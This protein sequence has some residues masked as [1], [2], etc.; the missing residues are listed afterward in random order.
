MMTGNGPR[1]SGSS[2]EQTIPAA[3]SEL[4]NLLQIVSG[5]VA[6]LEKVWEGQ[7]GS[8]KYFEMLRTT[9]DRASKVTDQLVRQVGGTEQ[10]ILFHP[11]LAAQIRARRPPPAP[12]KISRCILVVDDEP[13]AL[14]LSAQV[15]S[16]AGYTVVTTQSGVEALELFQNDPQRYSLV[17]LDLSMPLMDG[18]ETFDRLRAIDPNVPVVLNT[19]YV[20]HDRLEAMVKKGLAGFLRRPYQPREVIQQIEV[21]LAT[22]ANRRRHDPRP[23][24][25]VP[26]A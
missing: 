14:T 18:E 23:S 19:G 4:N 12:L 6:M 3:A 13:M 7:P 10:K 16:Q 17:L 9:V 21:I 26:S 11:V 25:P 15:L 24:P 1:R 2:L 22:A 5:T 20:E 8:E